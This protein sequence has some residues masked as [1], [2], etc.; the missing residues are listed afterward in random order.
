MTMRGIVK[1]KWCGRCHNKVAFPL[2]NCTRC[3]TVPK[4]KKKVS[5]K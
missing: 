2:S 5:K 3:H 4:K 1:G